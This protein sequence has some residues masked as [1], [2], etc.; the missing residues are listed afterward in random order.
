MVRPSDSA[1]VCPVTD[2]D[3]VE[4]DH[5]DRTYPDA[6]TDPPFSSSPP[7]PEPA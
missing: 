5:V 6:N 4:A 3:A 2:K 1:G 7:T